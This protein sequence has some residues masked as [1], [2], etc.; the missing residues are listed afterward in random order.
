[1]DNKQREDTSH[2]VDELI[3]LVERKTRT[4]RHLEQHSD[5]GDPERLIRPKEL[6]DQR[7][8]EIETLKEKI[9]Y[10]D[11]ASNDQLENVKRTY[12][13]SQGYIDHNADHMSNKDL[14]NALEK[15]E[16]RREQMDFLE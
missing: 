8:E 1:M 12:E 14:N 10:G 9:V 5:I 13:F 7:E 15:Q 2:R 4:E 3:N 6:Q 16:H 11:E